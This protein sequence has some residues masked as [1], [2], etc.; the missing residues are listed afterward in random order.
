MSFSTSSHIFQP[1][2]TSSS[3]MEMRPTEVLPPRPSNPRAHDDAH[4]RCRIVQPHCDIAETSASS[5]AAPEGRGTALV[6]QTTGGE[7]LL[8]PI[9]HCAVTSVRACVGVGVWVGGVSDQWMLLTPPRNHI[10]R[11]HCTN[12]PRRSAICRRPGMLANRRCIVSKTPNQVIDSGPSSKPRQA[13]K[14]SAKYWPSGCL[15]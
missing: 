9:A 10:C 13:S 8:P 5:G 3:T 6:T 11:P 15:P 7:P 14:D 4:G 12:W 2:H 1:R